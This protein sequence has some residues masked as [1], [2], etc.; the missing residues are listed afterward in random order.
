MPIISR[1]IDWEGALVDV[2]VGVHASRRE[3]LVRLQMTVPSA[4]PI[5]AQ[6]DTG[7]HRSGIDEGVLRSLELDGEVDIEE[8]FT[9]ST[10]DEPHKCPVYLAELTLVG[11]EGNRSFETLRVLAHHF[12][13]NEKAKAVIGRDLL[14]HCILEYDGVKRYFTLSF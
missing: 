8:V 14:A 9:S 7:T 3:K 1:T 11:A 4:I 13:P 5:P 2:L 12:S 10:T 6:I